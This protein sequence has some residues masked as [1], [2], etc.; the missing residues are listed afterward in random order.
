MEGRLRAGSCST[1]T[2]T[3]TTVPSLIF[4]SSRG[5]KTPFSYLAA[6]VMDLDQSYTGPT[7]LRHVLSLSLK[8]HHSP[9]RRLFLPLGRLAPPAGDP[10]HLISGLNFPDLRNLGRGRRLGIHVRLRARE[11]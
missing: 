7:L 5:R 6:M 2:R 4:T 8:R 3:S 11:A 9:P 1:G 10:I